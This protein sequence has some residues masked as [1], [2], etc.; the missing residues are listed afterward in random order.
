ML[1]Y[2]VRR[3]VAAFLVVVVTS[4]FV[5]ALFFLGPSNPASLLCNQN[6]RCTPRSGKPCLSTSWDSTKVS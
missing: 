1:G 4:M 6:G 3:L 2:I 5:F